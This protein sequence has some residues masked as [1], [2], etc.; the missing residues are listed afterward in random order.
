MWRV[1]QP[2]TVTALSLDPCPLNAALHTSN[3]RFSTRRSLQASCFQIAAPAWPADQ[4]TSVYS[5]A[6]LACNVNL[7]FRFCD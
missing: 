4:P 1:D 7:I 5:L 3:Q 6:A 2:A